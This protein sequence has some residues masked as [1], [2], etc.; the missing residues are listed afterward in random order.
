[1]T[2]P[3]PLKLLGSVPLF[4]GLTAEDRRLLGPL[5]HV[6]AYEKGERVFS[7]GE[8]AREICFVVLSRLKIVK[9]TPGR[10]LILGL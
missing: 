8:P 6:R 7:E 9:S 5:C 2:R 10:E 1:M 4:A 3:D